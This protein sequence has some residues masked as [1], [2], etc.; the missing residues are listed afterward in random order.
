MQR[1][2]CNN[3]YNSYLNGKSIMQIAVKDSIFKLALDS[4]Y[5]PYLDGKLYTLA[6]L[7]DRRQQPDTVK[8]RHILISTA[9]RDQQTGEMNHRATIQLLPKN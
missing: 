2:E 8:C 9:Q 4:V 3:F 6:K 7:L 5:G 1:R